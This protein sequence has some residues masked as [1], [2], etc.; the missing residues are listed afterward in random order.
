[1]TTAISPLG[2]TMA[3]LPVAPRYAKMLALAHQYDCLPY[4]VILVSALSV[5]EL[6][7]TSD[8]TTP[9]LIDKI[10]VIKRAWV[11]QVSTS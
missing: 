11:G 2:Q 3:S 6:F 10:A 4:M 5:R 1:M 7:V 9:H 8:E